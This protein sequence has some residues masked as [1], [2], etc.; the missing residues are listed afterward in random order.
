MLS[1][2]LRLLLPAPRAGLVYR[3]NPCR[4]PCPRAARNTRRIVV[5]SGAAEFVDSRRKL[6]PE[7]FD[8]PV[9][10]APAAEP[11]WGGAEVE[12]RKKPQIARVRIRLRRL[13]CPTER[14]C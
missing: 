7:P 8:K 2:A 12:N 5:A 1:R 3:G 4:A 14:N 11:D 6:G 10:A 13:A 9:E